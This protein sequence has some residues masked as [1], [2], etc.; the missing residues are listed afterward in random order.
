MRSKI[1]ATSSGSVL[2][3]FASLI[4]ASGY[5]F[6]KTPMTMVGALVRYSFARLTAAAGS[7]CSCHRRENLKKDLEGQQWIVLERG[8]RTDLMPGYWE[9]QTTGFEVYRFRVDIPRGA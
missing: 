1:A 5:F 3:N 8:Y 6:L 2:A 7:L 4:R 9:T